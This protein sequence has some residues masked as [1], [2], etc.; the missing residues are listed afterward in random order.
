MRVGI[1]CPFSFDVPGGVQFHVRDLAEE[2]R[3][4]GHR[5]SVLAPAEEGTDLPDY[6]VPAGRALAIPYNGSVARLSFGP[7]VGARVRRWVDEGAFDVLH[8]HEP[9]N[10]SLS[11]RALWAAQG[12][13]VAT[14]HSAME[15]SRALQAISPVVVPMF[16]KIAARIAVSEEA[17]RT[18]VQHVGGDAVVIPNGVYVD[19]FA[20]ARPDP[21]WVG[22]PERPTVAFLGR[23]DEP[24]KGLPVLAAA[25]GPV[26]AEVPGARFLIAGRGEAAEERALLARYGD[27]VE[28]L[29]GI[30][31][32]EKASLFASVDAYVAPQT[33]GESFGIVL[34]EALSAGTLVVAADLPAFQAVLDGGRYG[35]LFGRGDPASLAATLVAALTDPAGS[36]AVR[37]AGARAARSYDWS[38]VTGQVLAVYETVLATAAAPVREDPRTRTAMGLLRAATGSGEA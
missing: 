8:L 27:A 31:D 36:D 9:Y 37:Q 12:P 18:V 29:G 15:R 1:V 7:V 13:V 17:R 14:F 28:F 32:A 21:R 5:V 33:G 30:T 34:V 24:R 23:L 20:A 25:V 4:R 16:E 19:T 11:M 10:P 22:T 35:R 26:L 3:R 6:V 38:V 2:L